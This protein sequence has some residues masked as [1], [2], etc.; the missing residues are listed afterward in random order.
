MVQAYG[1]S[2][3]RTGVKKWQ[4]AMLELGD[5]IEQAGAE[6]STRLCEFDPP[7]LLRLEVELIAALYRDAYCD[8]SDH[9]PRGPSRRV[10]D[11]GHR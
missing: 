2:A 9:T 11:N 6:L 3:G 5:A 8:E 1:N 10:R 7:S 4:D